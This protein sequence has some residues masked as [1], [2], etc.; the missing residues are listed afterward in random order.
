MGT[1]R[2]D[3]QNQMIAMRTAKAMERIADQLEN[4]TL[5][6]LIEHMANE[7]IMLVGGSPHLIPYVTPLVP[8]VQMGMDV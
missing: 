7:P 2:F 4:P 5:Q 1:T 6:K 3:Q 8:Y